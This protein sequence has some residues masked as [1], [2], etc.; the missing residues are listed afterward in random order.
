MDYTVTLGEMKAGE[1]YEVEVMRGN[2]RITLKIVPA[3]R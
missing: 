2:Q 1:E 3:K